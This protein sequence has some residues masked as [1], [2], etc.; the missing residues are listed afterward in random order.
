MGSAVLQAAAL[1]ARSGTT[2]NTVPI[3]PRY[4]TISEVE[5]SVGRQLHARAHDG[6][7][8]SWRNSIQS[9]C[10]RSVQRVIA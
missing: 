9:D 2:M 1:A 4:I 8:E 6:K 3:R 7:H 10:M 5:Y